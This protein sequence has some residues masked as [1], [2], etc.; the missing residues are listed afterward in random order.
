ME[1]ERRV[2]VRYHLTLNEAE[3]MWLRVLIQ[4]PIN[5]D[6]D[7]NESERDKSMRDSFWQ[8]LRK[9]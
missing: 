1:G 5:C 9:E 2:T 8:A 6:L 7:E 3:A 4:N